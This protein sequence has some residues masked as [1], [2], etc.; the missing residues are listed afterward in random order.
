MSHPK[1][2]DV[3]MCAYCR[4]VSIYRADLT[5]RVPSASELGEIERALRV[6]GLL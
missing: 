5:L 6:S 4:G 1:E 2:N 3:A